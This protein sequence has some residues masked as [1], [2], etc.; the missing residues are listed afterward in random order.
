ME[1][2]LVPGPKLRPFLCLDGT[3]G[4]DVQVVDT[5]ITTRTP[6]RVYLSAKDVRNAARL[7]GYLEPHQA[8]ALDEDMAALVAQVCEKDA[9]IAELEGELAELQDVR[10]AISRAAERWQSEEAA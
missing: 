10:S 2:M 5:L 4:G 1:M 8:K 6:G 9:R 3:T 7:Y